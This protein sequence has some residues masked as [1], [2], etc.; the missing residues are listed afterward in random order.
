MTVQY[1]DRRAAAHALTLSDLKPEDCFEFLDNE[2]QPYTEETVRERFAGGKGMWGPFLVCNPGSKYL[3]RRTRLGQLG[4]HVVSMRTGSIHCR[5]KA[6]HVRR[7]DAY[8]EILPIG[9][10]RT[11]QIGEL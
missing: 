4:I 8:I 2:G 5:S 7:I 10:L 9:Q 3:S 11:W 6:T 1:V